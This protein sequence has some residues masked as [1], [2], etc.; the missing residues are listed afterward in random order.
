MNEN[1][2]SSVLMKC[3]H[4]RY[5]ERVPIWILEELNEFTS[6]KTFQ[7]CCPECDHTMYQKQK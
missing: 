7:M 2:E 3:E 6:D 5:E 1:T 4:C